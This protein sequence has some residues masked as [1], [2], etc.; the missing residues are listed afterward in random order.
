MIK[1]SDRRVKWGVG[2]GSVKPHRVAPAEAQGGAVGIRSESRF[3]NAFSGMRWSGKL[4][5]VNRMVVLQD[6]QRHGECELYERKCRD[7]RR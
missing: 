6:G 7:F 1:N 4:R 3:G 2:E 5:A